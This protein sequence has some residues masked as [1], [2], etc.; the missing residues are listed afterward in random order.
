MVYGVLYIGC[1]MYIPI[2]VRQ[3]TVPPAECGGYPLPTSS[4]TFVISLMTTLSNIG[5]SKCLQRLSCPSEDRHFLAESHWLN[6]W[7]TSASPSPASLLWFLPSLVL[8]E[9]SC[10]LADMSH[11]PYCH[12]SLR[13]SMDY[14]GSR[15][16][17]TSALLEFNI[18]LVSLSMCHW[19]NTRL[20]GKCRM[21]IVSPFLSV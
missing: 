15:L 3:F 13:V 19:Q 20:T 21:Y 4:S 16:H 18:S 9:S 11:L 17:W 5:Q 12:D 2:E 10:S 1:C 8:S 6:L 7:I 14:L